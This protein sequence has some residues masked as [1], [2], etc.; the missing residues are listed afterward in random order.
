MNKARQ[1]VLLAAPRTTYSSACIPRKRS[2]DATTSPTC[3]PGS[4][5]PV[6]LSVAAGLARIL[7]LLR[8]NPNSATHLWRERGRRLAPDPVFAGK[9][10][11]AAISSSHGGIVDGEFEPFPSRARLV[12][13]HPTGTTANATH[14]TQWVRISAP[15]VS[16]T[17]AG[18]RTRPLLQH[19]IPAQWNRSLGT[20]PAETG[21]NGD[22]A[23]VRLANSTADRSLG[24]TA[25]IYA[26]LATDHGDPGGRIRRQSRTAAP[27]LQSLIN[28]PNY[29][30]HVGR[31]QT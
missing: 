10:P 25:K 9:S 21:R 23:R 30:L 22:T 16:A 31:G 17:T 12:S 13:A 28:N 5:D 2:L 24:W 15:L 19:N 14:A 18:K 3:P 8:S 11:C 27:R 4:G 1:R 26:C 20:P 7:P 6:I 29:R